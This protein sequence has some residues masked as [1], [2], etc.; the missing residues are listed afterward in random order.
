MG[1]TILVAS[2][3]CV[4]IMVFVSMIGSL[5]VTKEYLSLENAKLVQMIIMTMAAFAACVLSAQKAGHGKMIVSV[6]TI[7]VLAG[8]FILIKLLFYSSSQLHVGWN[9][10]I[11]FV[12][13]VLA[14]L[15]SSRRRPRR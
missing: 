8:C 14:G 5:L 7:V 3:C 1:K 13:A 6:V 9:S 15:I 12:T 4:L 11:L 10:L 2:M